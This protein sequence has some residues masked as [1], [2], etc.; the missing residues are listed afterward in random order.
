MGYNLNTGDVIVTR[1]QNSRNEKNNEV[2]ENVR[3]L[4]II[5]IESLGVC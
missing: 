3:S 2:L 4:R 5:L 1:N